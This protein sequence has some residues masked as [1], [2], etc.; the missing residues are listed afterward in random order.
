MKSGKHHL[1]STGI[2]KEKSRLEKLEVEKEVN[3]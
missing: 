3:F 1:Q 2:N